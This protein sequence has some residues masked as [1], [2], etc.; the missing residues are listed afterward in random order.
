MKEGELLAD[1]F[2]PLNLNPRPDTGI[3]VCL[4]NL[5]EIGGPPTPLRD[6][7]HQLLFKDIPY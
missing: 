2:L 3:P 6:F 4:N 1:T 5:M 7:F